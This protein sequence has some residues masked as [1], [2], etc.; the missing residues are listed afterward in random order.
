VRKICARTD[1]A[2]FGKSGSA[3]K[4]T[5]ISCAV[6][7]N[8]EPSG[9]RQLSGPAATKLLKSLRIKAELFGP[10]QRAKRPRMPRG[11]P[12][13]IVL[14]WDSVRGAWCALRGRKLE[15]VFGSGWRE[16][17]NACLE[18]ATRERLECVFLVGRQ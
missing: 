18:I 15:R 4:A 7:A 5:T 10:E 16:A 14:R 1:E 3:S 17:A 2:G 9:M 6:S 8:R 13:S 12:Q 11:E